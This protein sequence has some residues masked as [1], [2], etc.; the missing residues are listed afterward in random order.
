[1]KGVESFE[2]FLKLIAS[3][4]VTVIVPSVGPPGIDVHLEARH[5]SKVMPGALHSPKKIRMASFID[6]DCSTI[7]QNNVKLAEVVTDQSVE[8]FLKPVASPQAGT[9]YA[10][11]LT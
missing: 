7:S 6:A 2:D 4:D 1:M 10:Y 9:H 5:N 3:P 8:S 11:T